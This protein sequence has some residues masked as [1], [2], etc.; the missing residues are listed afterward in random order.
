VSFWKARP[1][2]VG[3][4][5]REALESEPIRLAASGLAKAMAGEDGAGV[6]IARLEA[7][8]RDPV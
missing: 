7:L 1:E 4:R 3:P 8:A 6:A 2:L 5:I